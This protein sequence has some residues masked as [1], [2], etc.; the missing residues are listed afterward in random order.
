MSEPRRPLAI[1]LDDPDV[2]VATG[3][4]TPRF[5]AGVIVRPSADP[6]PVPVAEAAPVRRHS[7]WGAVFWSALG[8]LAT[9]AMGLAATRLIEDLFARND[10]LGY[11]GLGLLAL[12]GLAGL[13]IIIREIVAL[14]RLRATD[15][16]RARAER[17]LQTDDR[18]EGRAVVRALLDGPGRQPRLAR[19][20][21]DLTRN[22]AE[23]ID[24]ADLVRL[25]E[26]GLMAPLDAEA[27]AL[28]AASAKRVSLVTAVSPRA[29]VD[30]AFVAVSTISLIRKLAE[31]YGGRPGALAMARLVR[32][33][34]MH[35][36][37]TGGIA[38]TDS[39]L[40]QLV[41]HGLAARLSA[42]LGEGV[43]NGLLTARLGMA[44][45]DIIRPLPF[46]ALERPGLQDLAPDLINAAKDSDK[47]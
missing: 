12:A 5:G 39:V 36:A 2:R 16:L 17:V 6:L 46:A 37:L 40:Q 29:L 9:L 19:P 4:E 47:A 18:A 1:R 30:M 35:V 15:E 45:I 26:R 41:G 3:D 10:V 20:H 32:Q 38:A 23:I 8:G 43:L 42:K 25:A 22:L 27:K 31:L 7:R 13:V 44:A 21:A 34:F 11:A 28:V 24:G 33:V 14:A